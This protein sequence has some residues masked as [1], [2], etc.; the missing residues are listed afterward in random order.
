MSIGLRQLCHLWPALYNTLP[1]LG[2]FPA[3]RRARPL[4]LLTSCS[5]CW[6]LQAP[7]SRQFATK[8]TKA[9]GKGQPQAR[10]NINAALVD[11]IIN[12]NELKEEMLQI[13]EKLQDDYG[14]NLSIRTSPG[15]LDHI[16]VTIQDG[17]F[18]LNQLAQIS[19]KSPQ[20][21]LVNMASSPEATEAATKAIREC[22]MNL[23]PEVDGSLIRVPIPKVT[24]EHR[25][26]LG[27][28][29][30]QLTNKAKDSLRKVRGNAITRVKKTKDFVSEDTIRLIEKQIQQMADDIA[31]DMD[32]Q[33]VAKTKELL[34]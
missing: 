1:A 27:K 26:S 16:T 30:K 2:Q 17:K 22:G 25:E 32:K 9:K 10:V 6:A 5:Q 33:L 11:D 3:V 19:L 31:S 7:Q 12:L 20:L 8:K 24:R 14:K 4:A 28:L 29:A 21:I 15:A 18:P 13:V 34:G 23:N